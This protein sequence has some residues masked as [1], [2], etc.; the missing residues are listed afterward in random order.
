QQL[1][2][3]CA[4]FGREPGAVDHISPVSRE[5]N[6]VAGFRVDRTWFGVLSGEAA[7]ADHSLLASLHQDKAHLQKDLKLA[8]D[9]GRFAVSKTLRAITALEE[10]TLA[11]RHV[12]KLL[13]EVFYFPTG[14]QWGQVRQ[15]D[16]CRLQCRRIWIDR[17][18]R[19]RFLL[20]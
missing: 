7:E 13:L 15:L 20:P 14:H 1:G 11:S 18:L 8:G 4:L 12:G 9:G 19:R 10:K 5:G 17:L 6:P 2:V 3:G 16:Q